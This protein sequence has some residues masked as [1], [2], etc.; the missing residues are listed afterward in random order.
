MALKG[1][2]FSRDSIAVRSNRTL[3][4]ESNI[5]DWAGEIGVTGD[6]LTWA[7]GCH[8]AWQNAVASGIVESG[9]AEEAHQTYKQALNAC[10]EYYQ[11]AKDALIEI[12]HEFENPDDMEAAYGIRGE[13][14]RVPGLLEAAVNAL[15]MEHDK[16][17]AMVPPDPNVLP[18]AVVTN[19]VALKD[20]MISKYD[21]ALDERMESNI[22]FTAKGKL[23]ETDSAYF[24]KIFTLAKLVWDE[25]DNRLLALGFVPKSMIWT[26]NRPHAPKNLTFDSES[27]TFS[28][29]AVEDVDSYQLDCRLTGKKG[30]WTTIYEGAET[31]TSSKPPTAEEYDIRCRS[32]AG[33]TSGNWCTPIVVD[34]TEE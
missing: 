33:E 11:K 31:S 12:L 25:D 13:T 19:L 2:G 18:G 6:L 5:D 20:D 23:F 32:I 3:L 10:L 15:K 7:Q 27:G 22:T 16:R 26:H 8:T 4:M 21:I 29:D 28:W 14:P 17:V 30:D 9:E 1:N 24:R 34:F